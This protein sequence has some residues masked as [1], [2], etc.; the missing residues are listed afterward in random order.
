M[1]S[2]ARLLYFTANRGVFSANTTDDVFTFTQQVDVITPPLPGN[3]DTFSLSFT[4]ES[5]KYYDGT[6]VPDWATDFN[7]TFDFSNPWLEAYTNGCLC[8][9]GTGMY[10]IRKTPKRK[11]PLFGKRKG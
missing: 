11:I 8:F 9:P 3:T 4:L 5:L 7:V 6:T 10:F 1:E 2:H